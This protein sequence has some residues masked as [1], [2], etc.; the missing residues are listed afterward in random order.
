MRK[1]VDV[2]KDIAETFYLKYVVVFFLAGCFGF[3]VVGPLLHQ[4]DENRKEEAVATSAS[5]KKL[6]IYCVGTDKKNVAISFDAAWGA[7]D[8]D[9]LLK[10]LKE[11]DVKATFFLCGY[12]V[13]KYPEEVKKIFEAGH[14]IGNHS[15]TH[16]HGNQLSVQQNKDEI[17]A[18]HKKVKDLLG[19]DMFLYRPPF[20]EYNDT[21]LT[22]AEEC[23]YYSI[24]WDVDSLDW[25]NFGVEKEV[26]Q[27]LNHKHLGNG[28]IILFHNDAKYTPEALGT[29]IKGIKEK[30]F[31]IVP[32]ADLIYKDSYYIDHEGR[33]I[34]KDLEETSTSDMSTT[35]TTS[36]NNN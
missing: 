34:A 27:V 6:P 18:V 5:K 12:W 24:Q 25:K 31:Q 21:V 29:I 20:G 36:A 8:T 35:T 19:I 17:M 30:G 22:A 28:S 1:F 13:D 26:N 7:D 23:G 10:I 4:I 16:P 11:N 33:Q 15:N 2:L 32:I 9:D 3:G 14:T